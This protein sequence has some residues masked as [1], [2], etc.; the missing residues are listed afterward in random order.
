MANPLVGVSAALS[1]E[2]PRRSVFNQFSLEKK[3][4]LVTGG[5]R[6]IGLEVALGFAE[7][8]AVVYCLD[9]PT[10][11]DNDFKLAQ[12]YALA[13][14][15]SAPGVENGR[16]EYVS[17]DVSDQS[18]MWEIAEDIVAK[19]GRLDICFANAGIVNGA[20]SLEFPADDFT[21][22]PSCTETT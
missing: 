10:D 9:L 5:Q 7:A 8:G 3:V 16:L 19:E 21:K 20:T 11:P 2:T 18:Q 1:G 13:L 12:G 15:P 17:G 6:G 22:V 14:P 4:A